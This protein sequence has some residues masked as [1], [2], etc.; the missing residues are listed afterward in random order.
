MGA[1]TVTQRRHGAKR[2]ATIAER[3]LPGR[4]ATRTIAW[5]A[6][7][8]RDADCAVWWPCHRPAFKDS[9]SYLH[10]ALNLQSLTLSGCLGHSFI[11][12]H[13]HLTWTCLLIF[14]CLS[15][16]FLQSHFS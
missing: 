2:V 9:S 6:V 15:K 14:C 13:M 12:S 3:A 1:C 10:A 7:P 16:V 5:H 4:D 8:D 11:S